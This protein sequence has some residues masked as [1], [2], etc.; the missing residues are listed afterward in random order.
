VEAPRKEKNKRKKEIHQ[1]ENVLPSE[2]LKSLKLDSSKLGRKANNRELWNTYLHLHGD[3]F[4]HT[5]IF[6]LQ[7]LSS[8]HRVKS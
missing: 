8:T 2:K 7:C 1:N 6:W 5:W 4:S 3:I